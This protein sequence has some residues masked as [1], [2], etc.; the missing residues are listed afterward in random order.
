MVLLSKKRKKETDGAHT[1]VQPTQGKDTMDNRST[2]TV[3]NE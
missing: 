3:A 2:K 1:T